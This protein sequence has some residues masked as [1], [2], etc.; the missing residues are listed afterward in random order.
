MAD[1]SE[2]G[3]VFFFFFFFFWILEPLGK[4]NGLTISILESRERPDEI[5][6][7][8]SKS[9]STKK[10]YSCCKNCQWHYQSK[11]FLEW[12]FVVSPNSSL[13]QN[14]V[15]IENLGSSIVHWR[16][17]VR[18]RF[19]FWNCKYSFTFFFTWGDYS[20]LT[21]VLTWSFLF[22]LFA[23]VMY[24]MWFLELRGCKENKSRIP[25]SNIYLN[26]YYFSVFICW[27]K[28]RERFKNQKFHVT[29]E[30]IDVHVKYYSWTH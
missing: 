29:K 14:R 11:S 6:P 27:L 12:R 15:I 28:I 8:I 18:S 30:A 21:L 25:S 17:P 4:N 22:C 16:D 5:A 7:E 9:L 23:L 1:Q 26:Y 3:I 19:S 13:L 2:H 10:K 24:T 20:L